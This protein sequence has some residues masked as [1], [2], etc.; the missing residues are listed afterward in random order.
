M[1]DGGVGNE[2]AIMYFGGFPDRNRG[3]L[4]VM[5]FDVKAQL[6]G[7]GLR[8]NRC[9]HSIA[10]FVDQGEDRFVNVVVDQ[11]DSI[12]GTLYDAADKFMGIEYLSIEENTFDRRQGCADKKI[13]LVGQVIKTTVM[14]G[15]AA[16]DSVLHSQ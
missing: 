13:H 8:Y 14:V 4:P 11:H 12:H 6:P 2:K 1:I 15:E 5:A 16:I 10:A 9:V 7:E 3:V